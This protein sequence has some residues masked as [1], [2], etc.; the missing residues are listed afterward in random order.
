M[1][2]EDLGGVVLQYY[3]ARAAGDVRR[4]FSFFTPDAEFQFNGEGAGFPR[5]AD[6]AKGGEE[7]CEMLTALVSSFRLL[8]WRSTS[9]TVDG[10]TAVLAWKADVLFTA[11][12]GIDSF[13]AVVVCRFRNGKNVTLRKH[14]DTAKLA[15]LLWRR[16]VSA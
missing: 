9:L 7:V 15:K 1:S 2:K 10:D 14:T 13:E 6:R 4:A 11:T 5:M 3:Q 12:G 16:P 8:D